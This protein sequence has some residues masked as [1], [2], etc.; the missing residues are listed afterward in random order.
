MHGQ[1]VPLP[2]WKLTVFFATTL[3]VAI[4]DVNECDEG[5]CDQYSSCTNTE[6]SFECTCEAGFTGSGQDCNGNI[7]F[8]FNRVLYS[9]RYLDQDLCVKHLRRKNTQKR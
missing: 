3:S 6:G 4:V 9:F 7:K 1:K 2:A 5:P 8:S